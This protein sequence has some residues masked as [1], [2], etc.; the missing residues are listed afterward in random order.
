MQFDA[1]QILGLGRAVLD[2][3]GKVIS[4]AKNPK[5][6]IAYV[7]DRTRELDEW[8]GELDDQIKADFPSR[9]E[10]QD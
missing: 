4:R 5:Q 10:E 3:V 6:A 8:E 2:F 1:S 9:D 7:E